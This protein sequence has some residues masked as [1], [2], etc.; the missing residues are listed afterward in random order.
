VTIGTLAELVQVDV[1]A[2]LR[3]GRSD[4][5]LGHP[6]ASSSVLSGRL[7]STSP[8]LALRRRCRSS[9]TGGRSSEADRGGRAEASMGGAVIPKGCVGLVTVLVDTRDTAVEDDTETEP[10]PSV[11]L[12]LLSLVAI[13][14]TPP[15][16]G[17]EL[18]LAMTL[19]GYLSAH[20]PSGTESRSLGSSVMDSRVSV[21]SRGVG[22]RFC[23]CGRLDRL[24][25]RVERVEDL[26]KAG[27][28]G[29]GF[30]FGV[31]GTREALV[32]GLPGGQA[33]RGCLGTEDSDNSG[34][35]RCRGT[36]GNSSSRAAGSVGEPSGITS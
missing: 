3:L 33:G 15:R 36:K 30:G 11:E 8:A 12:I 26:R 2:M 31:G 13:R 28:L 14:T 34:F 5:G 9:S 24:G 16:F 22:R 29:F 4:G 21:G 10:K 23:L 1:L 7:G 18:D 32:L 17:C 6:S 20:E 35:G 19:R 27:G 25:G